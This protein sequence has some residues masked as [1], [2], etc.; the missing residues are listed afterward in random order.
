VGDQALLLICDPSLGCPDTATTAQNDALCLDDYAPAHSGCI[1]WQPVWQKESGQDQSQKG[2]L[3]LGRLT[4]GEDH[5][6]PDMTL[7]V[8]D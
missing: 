8:Y 7:G 5:A 6:E 4:W 1:A 3:G 2:S